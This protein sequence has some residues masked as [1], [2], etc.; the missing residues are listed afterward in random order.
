MNR[1]PEGSATSRS[2]TK[3]C[4]D[5]NVAGWIC[6]TPSNTANPPCNDNVS[7]ADNS[8]YVSPLG[9]VLRPSNKS[10]VVMSLYKQINVVHARV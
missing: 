10:R 2:K 9:L 5:A 4:S 8:Q 7:N 6:S 1:L 3:R